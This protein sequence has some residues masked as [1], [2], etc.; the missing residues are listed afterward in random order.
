MIGLHTGLA[1]W[2]VN[3]LSYAALIG[4]IY[5][6]HHRFSFSSEAAH[7]RAMPRYLAVQGMALMLTAGFSYCAH[8]ILGLP[9]VPASIL[10]VGLTA[11]VNY[12]VLRHWAFGLPQVDRAVPA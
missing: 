10:V 5:L 11:S 3:T 6:L 8:Q 9:A 2:L 12:L 7:R 4:P 1:N